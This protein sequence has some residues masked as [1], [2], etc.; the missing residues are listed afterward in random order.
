MKETLEEWA[1]KNPVYSREE[2]LE[3]LRKSFPDKSISGVFRISASK[4]IYDFEQALRELGKSNAKKIM[5]Q[6][7]LE[8]AAE[9]VA[10]WNANPSEYG[11]YDILGGL[12]HIGTQDSLTLLKGIID[13]EEYDVNEILKMVNKIL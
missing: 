3:L 9:L 10:K 8:E 4:Q 6:E 13:N 7:T 1:Y 11:L 2:I 12:K 5:K